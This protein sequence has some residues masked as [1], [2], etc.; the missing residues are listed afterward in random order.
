ME[1]SAA[2]SSIRDVAD[3]NLAAL[4]GVD[5]LP[6]GGLRPYN[7]GSGEPHTVGEM[8]A[9]LARGYAGPTPVVTGEYRL[10][11]VRHITAC[12]QRLRDEFGWKPHMSFVE[13]MTE[14]AA[15]PLRAG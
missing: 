9:A 3:V 2:T 8:A 7:V 11:D 5:G 10:G 12:S 1:R 6:E 4:G 13:G 14:F 15:A